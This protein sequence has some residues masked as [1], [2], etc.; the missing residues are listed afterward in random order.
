MEIMK[1]YVILK[2]GYVTSTREKITPDSGEKEYWRGKEEFADLFNAYLFDGEQV[3]I[4]DELEEQD[5]DVSEVL[6]IGEIKESIKGARDVIKIAKRFRGVEFAIL[7][8]ENQEGIHYAM[9]IRVMGY[10]H[11]TYNKQYQEKKSYYK[12]NKVNLQGD[13]FISGIKKNDRFLPVITLVLHYGE[14][15]WD[16][17]HSLNDMLDIPDKMRKYVSDYHINVVEIKDNNLKLKNQNNIDLFKLLSIIYDVEKSKE[18]RREELRLYEENR[19]IDEQVVDAVL[20]A[21]KV[22]IKY[23]KAGELKMCTLWDEVREEGREEGRMAGLCQAIFSSV[24]EGD[25]G[26]SRGAEKMGISIE[27]FVQKMT[28]AGY[29][30]P[31]KV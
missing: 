11:Y 4:A 28:E 16:G 10:D 15:E 5:T 1:N 7:A 8:I 12:K 13:E 6:E 26:V 14:E 29:K 2:E 19:Q 3:I 27:E 17:P 30:I 31:E 9:P 22:N 23:N 25:Y 18:Q 21:T 20:A 24:Q